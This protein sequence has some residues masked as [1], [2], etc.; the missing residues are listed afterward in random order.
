[1]RRMS[2]LCAGLP[3]MMT[4]SFVRSAPSRVSRRRLASRF[5]SSGPWQAKQLSEKSGSTSRL[6]STALR[7]VAADAVV[8]EPSVTTSAASAS[9]SRVAGVDFMGGADGAGV[10]TARRAY[11]ASNLWTVV[12]L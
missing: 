11:F 4:A 2:S 7:C 12:V 3:G 8:A 10:A 6:K 5:F 1:M 9:K